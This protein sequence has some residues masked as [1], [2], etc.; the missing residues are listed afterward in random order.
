MVSDAVLK[1]IREL[2]S[3]TKLKSKL[4]TTKKVELAIVIDLRNEKGQTTLGRIS[5][6]GNTD[7]NK[8]YY[9]VKILDEAFERLPIKTLK[10]I[11]LH[12]LS[13]IPSFENAIQNKT[14]KQSSSHGSEF[15]KACKILHT[16]K[17]FVC[18]RTPIDKPT[19]RIVKLE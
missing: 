3:F 1:K 9:N 11:I 8:Y 15:K 17:E 7:T 6:K 13:H 12:E 19:R 18:A 14:K 16:P 2:G 4:V 10:G 5:V